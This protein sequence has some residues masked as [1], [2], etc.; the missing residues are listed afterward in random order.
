MN[1]AFQ[2]A[3]TRA[4]GVLTRTRWPKWWVQFMIRVLVKTYGIAVNE[5]EYPLHTFET[6]DQFFTRSLQPERR[7][8][9]SDGLVVSPTDGTV[10]QAGPIRDGLLIQAKGRFYDAT[11]LIGDDTLAVTTGTFATIYLSP[12]DCHRMM[13]P[14]DGRIVKTIYTPGCLYPVRLHQLDRVPHL[15]CQ[16]ERLTTLFETSNGWVAMVAVGALNVGAISTRF[17]SKLDGQFRSDTCITTYPEPILVS[18]GDWIKTFHLGST[19]VLIYQN[20]AV[21]PQLGPIQYGQVIMG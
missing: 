21:A 16:N 3:V 7:P 1:R 11:T 17:D 15:Y 12:K 19:V 6:V 13:S 14:V 5:S 9:M 20:S 8:I 18:R 4:T 10:I 2:H